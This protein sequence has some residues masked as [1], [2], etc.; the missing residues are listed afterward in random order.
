MELKELLSIAGYSG[1]F[2]YVSQG[3]NGIIVEGLEDKKRM[4]AFAHF[5]VSSLD[6]IAIFAGS[7][8]VPLRKIF[9]TIYETEN[10]G[11][12]FG[13]KIDEKKLKEYF[14]KI[15]PDYDREKVYVSDIKKVISWYNIL[16]RNGITIFLEEKEETPTAEVEEK[17]LKKKNS[18]SPRFFGGFLFLIT[19]QHKQFK[20]NIFSNF[21]K[22]LKPF[23]LNYG[24]VLQ[25]Q[26]KQILC[27]TNKR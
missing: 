7:G 6:D 18:A 22:Q 3:R 10:G 2:K 19:F 24:T 12:A 25:K 21:A 16:L 13:G 1:L 5:K 15:L 23:K 17:K 27:G 14:T 8:E 4:N 26:R 11:Q 9:K 20:F